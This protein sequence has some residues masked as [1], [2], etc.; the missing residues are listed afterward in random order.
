MIIHQQVVIELLDNGQL[1]LYWSRVLQKH[2]G[3][4]SA[5]YTTRPEQS[6]TKLLQPVM[7]KNSTLDL[8]CTQEFTAKV[9]GTCSHG[10]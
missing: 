8:R 1:T 10:V 6:Q 9:V 5:Y 4:G 2:P 3:L 7:I